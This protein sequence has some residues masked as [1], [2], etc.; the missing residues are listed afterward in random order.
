MLLESNKLLLVPR[1]SLAAVYSSLLLT[2]LC[3]ICYSRLQLKKSASE[4][5]Y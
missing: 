3:A 1:P 5:I 2:L 4:L